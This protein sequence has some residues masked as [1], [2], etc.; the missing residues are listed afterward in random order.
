VRINLEDSLSISLLLAVARLSI[1]NCQPLVKPGRG[2]HALG[3]P[4]VPSLPLDPQLSIVLW[5]L[6]P[7]VRVIECVS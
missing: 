5:E 2:G 6:L 7:A 1:E 4:A 3:V